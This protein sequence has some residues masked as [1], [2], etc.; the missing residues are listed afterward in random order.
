MIKLDKAVKGSY[1]WDKEGQVI[2]NPEFIESI[3]QMYSRTPGGSRSTAYVLITMKSGA[4]HQIYG[5]LSDIEKK[6]FFR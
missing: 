5:D 4:T 3:E 1:W 2:I 6:V